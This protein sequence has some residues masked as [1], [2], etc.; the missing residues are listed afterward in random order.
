MICHQ[1]TPA[2]LAHIPG[3]TPIARTALSLYAQPFDNSPDLEADFFQ[4]YRNTQ[5]LLLKLLRAPEISSSVVIASG[6]AMIV[7][8]GALK[9]VLRAGDLVLCLGNGIFGNGFVPMATAC[10]ARVIHIQSDYHEPLDVDRLHTEFAHERPR[11][12]TAVHCDTPSGVLNRCMSRIG[13]WCQE[14]DA[15][16]AV[17]FVASAFGTD[18]RVEDWHIDLGLL[19]TQKGNNSCCLIARV[20][21]IAKCFV[22]FCFS[23]INGA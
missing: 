23:S 5:T 20:V 22:A 3:P 6:E 17:D 13:A 2:L 14:R 10:G 15:L 12:V 19:G 9:S 4:L 7:L 11:L 21:L 8:W 1:N 18:V 16:F